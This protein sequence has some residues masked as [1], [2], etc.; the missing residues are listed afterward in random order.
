MIGDILS[1][2]HL[3]FILVVALLFLGPK[4]LPEA[5]RALGKGLREF[6]S[7]ISGEDDHH[8]E[9]PTETPAPSPEAVVPPTA[10]PSV[11]YA[12]PVAP[13]PPP[14]DHAIQAAVFA[15]TP[16]E[17]VTAEPADD[18]TSEQQADR[19]TRSADRSRPRRL[20]G[21]IRSA[22]DHCRDRAEPIAP[23]SSRCSNRSPPSCG[24]AALVEETAAPRRPSATARGR[25]QIR[26]ADQPP[27]G[28]HAHPRR[29][30]A[31]RRA[32]PSAG[33][34]TEC[35]WSPWSTRAIPRTCAR[36]T[37]GRPSCSS[38]ATRSARRDAAWR[39][40]AHAE[41]P[42][43]GQTAAAIAQHLVDADYTVV[44]G[45]AAGI[46]TAAHTA[47]L[48]HGGRTVAVIGT[49]LRRSYPAQNAACSADRR[50]VRGDLAVLARRAA[51]STQLPDAQRRDVR[52]RSRHRGRRGLTHKRRAHA[53]TPRARAARPVF[54]LEGLSSTLGSE[55]ARRGPEHTSSSSPEQIT[56]TLD[57]LISPSARRISPPRDM[58]TVG[59]L[60]GLYAKSCSSPAGSR[61][62]R[63][64]LHLH[65]RIRA[66]LRLP[67][68]RATLDVV[69]PVSYSV[70]GEQ[71]HHALAG[72]KRLGGDVARRLQA[73]W[74]Q[75]SGASSADHERCIATA[76]GARPSRS[77]PRSRQAT[78]RD[79]STPSARSSAR[80]SP[81]PAI[82]TSACAYRSR[83]P[84]TNVQ[85]RQMST[86]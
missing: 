41:H 69:V 39:S 3:L 57:R 59:E 28:G 43:A 29:T 33:T 40:S 67:A 17:D 25:K 21:R 20:A 54:L 5:G 30:R 31:R 13:T 82:A 26:S 53:G 58:P 2:T 1:P 86:Q 44:S 80:S 34:P 79:D 7:A 77:S 75:S 81:P 60:T 38:P 48:G 16:V 56:T 35:V 27:P 84:R 36:C 11:T 71:L 83:R 50:G 70:A 61:G 14:A 10:S 55:Y 37:T 47:A 62:V 19:L 52:L 46:D 23:R 64:L 45:L 68:R 72:Y 73:S 78:E 85:R 49:G 63:D 6:R 65:R 9:R 42:S 51:H 22:G 66:L 4:R 15:A 24:Y 32:K 12:E 76:G 8:T 74:P 18:A